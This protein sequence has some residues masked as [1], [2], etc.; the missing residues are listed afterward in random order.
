M[1]TTIGMR[2]KDGIILA[3]D[4]EISFGDSKFQEEKIFAIDDIQQ[5]KVFIGYA[6]TPSLAKEAVER[7]REHLLAL[8]KSFDIQVKGKKEGTLYEDREREITNTDIR[9]VA[10][11][12]L[13][14][15]ATRQYNPLALQLLI[16]G[17][18]CREL[19]EMWIYD[20]QGFLTAGDFQPLAM[21][22]LSIVQHLKVMYSR[23]DTLE[24]GEN[25]AV[26]LMSKAATKLSGTGLPIDVVSIS[27]HGWWK[28]MQPKE[29]QERLIKMEA[30]EKAI[31]RQLILGSYPDVS[32]TLP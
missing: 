3:A 30:Q 1:T 20:A 6:D 12:V 8:D 32:P 24:I 27:N 15:M 25:L 16:V 5:W 22:N 4:Q 21:G 9:R 14:T 31:L 18:G 23:R 29:F 26:Y 19:P 17:V 2:F 28:W 7:I 13:N 10:E 11:E